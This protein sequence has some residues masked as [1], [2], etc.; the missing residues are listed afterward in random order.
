GA[1]RAKDLESAANHLEEAAKL[2]P[3][4]AEIG[5]ALAEVYANPGFREGTDPSAWRHKAGE[6]FVALG[7]RRLATRDDST[8]INYLR[9][10]VGVDPT[11]KA[12]SQALES[13]LSETSQWAELDRILRHRSMVVT[14]PGERV[15]VLRRRAALYRNQLPNHDGL[16][17][18]L[19]ELLAY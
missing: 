12:P 16:I 13:A 11:A 14:D 2:D 10:A 15:E 6:L 19:S 3:Q 8:G 9:R 17:E 1:L 4:S 5:E 18:V 7:R